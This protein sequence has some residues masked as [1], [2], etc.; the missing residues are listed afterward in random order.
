[1]DCGR[2][3]SATEIE[4]KMF[5]IYEDGQRTVFL[6]TNWAS[7]P[8]KNKSLFAETLNSTG[9]ESNSCNPVDWNLFFGGI[10]S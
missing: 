4:L 9:N 10:S 5:R 7:S 3:I 6:D 1:M 2:K 8:L